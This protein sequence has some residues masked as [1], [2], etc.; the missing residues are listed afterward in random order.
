MCSEMFIL[1]NI[2]NVAQNTAEAFSTEHDILR[3]YF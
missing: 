3:I 2:I 1:I